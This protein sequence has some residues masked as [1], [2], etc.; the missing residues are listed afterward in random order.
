MSISPTAVASDIVIGG[1][2]L[3][4]RHA[5]FRTC[6]LE[7]ARLHMCDVL[8]EHGVSYLPRQR[9]LDFR[10]RQA[11]VSCI[12]LNSLE[13]GAGVMITAPLLPDFYLLQ[14][15]VVGACELW[16]GTNHSVLSAG[17]VAIVNPNRGFR[18]LWMPG[19]RQ[20]LLRIDRRLVER[21]F[22]AW[23]GG[24]DSS[25]ILFD[26]PPIDD[27]AKVGS[28]ARYVRMLCDD[29]KNEASNLLHPLV[30]DRVASG[31]VSLL[32]TSMPHNKKRAVEAAANRPIAPFFVRRVEQFIAQRARDAITL[33]DLTG[34]AGVSTRALQTSFR[35]FRNMTPM[36]YLRMIRLEL[37]RTELAN[38]G[39]EGTSVAAV[40]TAVGF[41]H[42]GRFARDYQ[43]RFGELPSQTLRRGSVGRPR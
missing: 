5:V 30:A 9:H 29:L 15:T 16:Q 2:A 22:R 14:F 36:D 28:L 20:L 11:R 37:A 18:K 27:M 13:W 33:A 17:S 39:Q 19:T 10:H 43:A 23:T 40:A 4:P 35:R 25:G 12:A 6:D 1:S 32:L 38:A 8:G 24:D 26:M 3:L 42:L 7:Q 41:G 31:L 21:E 34:I